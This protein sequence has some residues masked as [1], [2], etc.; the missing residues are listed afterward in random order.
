M[1][2]VDPKE[3]DDLKKRVEKLEAASKDKPATKKSKSK[4]K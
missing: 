4:K 3:F 2:F 1:K